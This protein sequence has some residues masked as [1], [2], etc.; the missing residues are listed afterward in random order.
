MKRSERIYHEIVDILTQIIPNTT[1][2]HELDDL[3]KLFLGQKFGG[4]YS[5]D[6]LPK[7]K[8]YYIVNL[9]TSNMPGSH[10]VGVYRDD[11][12]YVYDSFGR[13]NLLPIKAIYTENDKEQLTI[14][15]N[16]GARSLAWLILVDKWGIGAGLQ[17]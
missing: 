1:S 13:E 4:V 17:I 15:T 12:T 14:S 5:S 8:G 9:D 7:E 11:E 3:G 10:W 2:N 6:T 16:C